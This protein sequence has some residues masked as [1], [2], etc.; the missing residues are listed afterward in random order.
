MRRREGGGSV[1]DGSEQGQTTTN[2]SG[3][4][5]G[6]TLL[7]ALRTCTPS[8]SMPRH[9]SFKFVVWHSEQLIFILSFV[10]IP[11]LS[12]HYQPTIKPNHSGLP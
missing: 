5:P 1:E 12:C 8:E 6:Y 3:P 11:C 4:Q 2:E 9:D 7:P 10:R